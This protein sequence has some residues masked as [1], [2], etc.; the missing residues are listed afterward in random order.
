VDVRTSFSYFVRLFRRSTSIVINQFQ[1]IKLTLSSYQSNALAFGDSPKAYI[2]TPRQTYRLIFLLSL[3]RLT[4]CVLA[5]RTISN[6]NANFPNLLAVIF[7]S[8]IF[9]SE[10]SVTAY[11]LEEENDNSYSEEDILAEF[12]AETKIG[13]DD[14]WDDRYEDEEIGSNGEGTKNT[15]ENNDKKPRKKSRY[16]GL[17]PRS[18]SRT[19][20]GD[21]KLKPGTGHGSS[22]LK[23]EDE[24]VTSK[25]TFETDSYDWFSEFANTDVGG[26]GNIFGEKFDTQSPP[27]TDIPAKKENSGSPPQ[28]SGDNGMPGFQVPPEVEAELNRAKEKAQMAERAARAA[29]E[30]ASMDAEAE[31]DQIAAEARER[32][33][34]EEIASM[35]NEKE[36]KKAVAKRKRDTLTVRR[37][38]RNSEH[39]KHYA[40]L[41]LNGRGEIAIRTL[42]T[43]LPSYIARSAMKRL[44]VHVTQ[45]EIKAAYRKM[46]RRVHPDKNVDKSSLD[47]FRALERSYA[48][49][50][51]EKTRA[52]Y[53]RKLGRR[54]RGRRDKI[55]GAIGSTCS[56][57]WG[58]C[59]TLKPFAKPIMILGGLVV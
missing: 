43:I 40:V 37:L 3:L 48:I 15:A 19:S 51:D 56:A 38:I 13:V 52:E 27:V 41:G 16:G 8:R 33:V 4:P 44:K 28:E 7:S 39:D 10:I 6:L 57:A 26:D 53:D 45:G 50:G 59:T 42:H 36:R 11:S 2:S 18:G 12:L 9:P 58:A 31:A 30:K 5:D 25:T 54:A 46:A 55:V 14:E 29:F 24:S 20:S 32:K 49:L 21:S 22:D 47:A 34:E 35:T 17:G 23:K 1:D